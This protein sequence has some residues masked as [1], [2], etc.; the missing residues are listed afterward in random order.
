MKMAGNCRIMK[1][2]E[3]P[4]LLRPKLYPG[5]SGKEGFEN[6]WACIKHGEYI[7][8]IKKC[9]SAGDVKKWEEEGKP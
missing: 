4:F 2:A 1:V 7:R 6:R 3:C 5:H 9:S 8:H